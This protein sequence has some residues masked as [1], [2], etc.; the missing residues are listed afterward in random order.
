[1]KEQFA[2]LAALQPNNPPAVAAAAS[3]DMPALSELSGFNKEDV[4]ESVTTASNKEVTAIKLLRIAEVD[5]GSSPRI[6]AQVFPDV[7]GS[8]VTKSSHQSTEDTADASKSNAVP[9]AHQL[10]EVADSK[11]EVIG[12][13][14]QQTASHA[15]AQTPG[16]AVV[17]TCEDISA[18]GHSVGQL[19]TEARQP[20]TDTV[21]HSPALDGPAQSDAVVVPLIATNIMIGAMHSSTQN[22][23]M[24]A[25]VGE[26]EAGVV[27]AAV[28]SSHSPLAA[29]V[30]AVPEDDLSSASFAEHTL[31]EADVRI[32]TDPVV[33]D[34]APKDGVCAEEAALP[35]GATPL[36]VGLPRLPL[37]LEYPCE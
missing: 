10:T 6:S 19:S 5:S 34:V 37:L 25:L 32:E 15:C 17:S 12:T 13:V 20:N 29:G 14:Q 23:S 22:N 2:A 3:A 21:Q 33:T 11:P 24:I 18:K 26:G 35:A 4:S 7:K 27:R 9:A 36:Q 31:G 30:A 16:T 8:A 28:P 1:M